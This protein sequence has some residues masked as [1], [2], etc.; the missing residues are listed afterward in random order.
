MN[1]IYRAL[2]EILP[3]APLTVVVVAA[4][5]TGQRTSIVTAPGGAQQRV[6]GADLPV[7]SRAFV[8]DGVIEGEAPDLLNLTIEV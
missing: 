3:Q 8:R 2:K 4:V 1:N 7:G 6:R 5:D